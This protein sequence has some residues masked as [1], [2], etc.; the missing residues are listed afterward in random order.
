M[1]PPIDR[2]IQIA[3]TRK[4]IFL[5]TSGVIIPRKIKE[6]VNMVGSSRVIFGTDGP[7][8]N[9]AELS[10]NYLN[11]KDAETRAHAK[12]KIKNLKAKNQTI[13]A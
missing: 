7:K 10:Q 1:K 9:G 2:F 4:N 3:K 8:P 6:A 13:H 11:S 5:D 12:K